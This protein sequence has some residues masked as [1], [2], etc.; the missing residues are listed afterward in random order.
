MVRF[1]C[2][3]WLD[4][5]YSM[6][7][8]EESMQF[9]HSQHYSTTPNTIKGLWIGRQIEIDI[10]S[11]R[12]TESTAKARFTGPEIASERWLECDR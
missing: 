4:W 6:S 11:L 3:V 7:E 2:Y 9:I 12:S 10:A 5:S 8:G 1:F